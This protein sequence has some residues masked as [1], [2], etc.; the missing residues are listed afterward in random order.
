M[1]KRY[2]LSGLLGDRMQHVD[3]SVFDDGI[4]PLKAVIYTPP[5]VLVESA[6]TDRTPHRL[7]AVQAFSTQTSL[8]SVRIDS[9]SAQ[10]DL[11]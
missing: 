11:E 8:E 10:T 7:R 4:S 6:Q 2:P 3:M 5:H 1:L 9:D